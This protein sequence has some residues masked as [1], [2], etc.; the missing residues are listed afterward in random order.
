MRPAASADPLRERWFPSSYS[1]ERAI[2]TGSW[3]EEPAQGEEEKK[4][5]RA[6]LQRA[7]NLRFTSPLA[8]G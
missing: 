3:R 4:K 5:R 6:G 8:T 1:D 2:Q 7:I